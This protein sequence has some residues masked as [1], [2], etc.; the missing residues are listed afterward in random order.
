MYLY[1]FIIRDKCLFVNYFLQLYSTT[2]SRGS[3]KGFGKE[4]VLERRGSREGVLIRGAAGIRR[5]AG[6]YVKWTG[7]RKVRHSAKD[8]LFRFL[9]DKDREAL[10]QL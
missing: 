1:G 5:F 6:R 9:F 7:C 3:R 2:T 8:R 4:D 10:L